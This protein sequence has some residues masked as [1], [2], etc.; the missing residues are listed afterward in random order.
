MKNP[1]SELKAAGKL[2]TVNNNDNST[3]LTYALDIID[4]EKLPGV[5]G[6]QSLLRRMPLD[7]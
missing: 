1:D 3:N 7:F 4:A 5:L 2:T 6:L